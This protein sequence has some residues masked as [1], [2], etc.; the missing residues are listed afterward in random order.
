MATKYD[1]PAAA[2]RSLIGKR[3]KRVDGPEKA[4]GE[5]KY[6]Y[7][8]NLD[9]MLYARLVTSTVPHGRIIG[10]DT[11]AAQR[12][13]GYKGHVNIVN[14]G[15]EVQ[16]VGTEILAICAD[17]E[18][19]ARDAAAAVA[20]HFE[21]LPHWVKEEDVKK[22]GEANRVK[23]AKDDTKGPDLD[24]AWKSADATVAG[25]YGLGIITHCCLEPHGQVVDW[26]ADEITVY[27]STQAVARIPGDLA[28]G[29]SRDESIGTISADSIHVITPYMGGG[30]GSKFNIDTWGVACAKLSKQ[31]GKPVKL[32]L[33][34]DEELMVAG[35]R[36]SDYGN[37]KIGAK[38][39]GTLVAYESETWS[40][41]GVAGRGSPP[42]PYV[43]N[44]EER[45]AQK[46]RH[47][48]VSTNIGPA[49][50]WR[51]PNHPQAAVLTMCPMEDLA[52]KLDMDPV[53]F[54]KKNADLTARPEVYR[55]EIDKCAE[56][57]G[58]KDNWHKRGDSGPGPVKRGLGLSLHT[59]GGR[60]HDSTCEVRIQPDG[61]VSVSMASQ[62]LGVGTYT[63]LSV[64]AAETL[65]LQI[66]DIKVN[67]G[68][69]KLPISGASGGSTTVGG[70]SASTRRA[71]V[72]ALEDLKGVVAGSLG[73]QAGDLVAK[74][75]KIFSKSD[76]SKSL[77]WKDA[78]K[79]L[80]TRTITGHGKQPDRDGGKLNDSGVGG[81]QMAD[82]SV[83]VETGVVTINKIAAV[84]DVGL[85]ICLE[86]CES[87]VY[88]S[89]I[90]GVGWA[91]Y[92]ESIYDQAT[93]KMLN[94]DMEFY[95][96]AGA[97][98]IGELEVHMVQNKYDDRGV[99]GIGE[100]PAISPGAAISNA[101]A[102]AIG[103][104][105]P[106][107]P[108]TPDRVLAALANA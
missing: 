99:I 59:W 51:A 56:M 71:T 67:I 86:Q 27:A 46:A 42:L 70:T 40:T 25:H 38:K 43:Y 5:A 11:S 22:A 91:L 32:M 73:V 15:D 44:N 80:G 79:K 53:E 84:Q 83:D 39:D 63:T 74:E 54:F 8:R 89:L 20:V 78:C 6:S 47:L 60:P 75:G 92:E 93:G 17:T 13:S 19:H 31:T 61:G 3:H 35:G 50:A 102:N 41:G 105:V 33:D 81:V 68:S 48:N 103:V 100:P 96:L 94:P 24:A 98:D 2:D 23:P 12:V 14:V 28:K 26:T 4:R 52:A 108:L 66:P 16:W 18:E 107:L 62:D 104:R 55:Y 9:G 76:D 65:G 77:S 37:I 64:V 10:I 82:V 87:Q 101:V 97:G 36:P 95:K 29:L 34:R 90:Q 7:D 85:V 21:D 106:T 58:W 1:W 57:I 69:S 49:R 72:N 45:L 88:G 30:F